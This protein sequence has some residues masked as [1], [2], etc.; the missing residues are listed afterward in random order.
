VSAAVASTDRADRVRELHDRLVAQV[1]AL[2]TG[3]DW[4]R[5]LS[6][7]ARFHSYSANN[8]WLILAQ[9]PDL[10]STGDRV[11]GYQTWKR[12]GRQV[13]AG[14]KGIA[15]LAP[16]V[17][18][19]RGADDAA[20]TTAP[21]DRTSDSTSESAGTAR[22]LRGFKVVHVFAHSD[23]AGDPLPD[24]AAVLLEGEGALWDALAAQVT[25]AGFSVSRGDCGSAN[26]CTNFAARTVVVAEHLSG[27]QADKTLAHDL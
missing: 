8:L 5:Y 7:A 6:V 17:Y 18:R 10:A 21:A 16:C 25:A 3:E 14:S 1:E 24:V 2:V 4:A 12:L 19:R 20:P 13:Q 22:V 23:T 27:R 15:I 11:A 26:G 9:R